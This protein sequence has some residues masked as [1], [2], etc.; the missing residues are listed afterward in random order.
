MGN[1]QH[2][3]PGDKLKVSASDWNAVMD[4]TRDLYASKNTMEG[5]S[6][7]A[8]L[9]NSTIVRAYNDTDKE[10]GFGEVVIL[11]D[12]QISPSDNLEEFALNTVF[13][14]TNCDVTYQG[15]LFGIAASPIQVGSIGRVI[16]DGVSPALISG[17]YTNNRYCGV[18]AY[19]RNL[20]NGTGS[21]RIVAISDLSTKDDNNEDTGLYWGIV[22]LTHS[23]TT[24][25]EAQLTEQVIAG[26][27][28]KAKLYI[29]N[30]P[31]DGYTTV[32]NRDTITVY[33]PSILGNNEYYV[34]GTKVVV[35]WMNPYS[36]W[37]IISATCGGC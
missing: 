9:T 24:F 28:G 3:N 22:H 36:R 16:I 23:H 25:A 37:Q 35:A 19:S 21:C 17:Y 7:V 20:S 11:N 10:F 32:S 29:C 13:K 6:G 33:A 12:V 14:G 15:E 18:S 5:G 4:A 31:P 30:N 27:H 34:V 26:G 8:R 1:F 2:L